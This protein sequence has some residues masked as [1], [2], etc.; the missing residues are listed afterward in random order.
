MAKGWALLGEF[1]DMDPA[2]V[3]GRYFGCMHHEESRIK[4]PATAH[5]FHEDSEKGT[6]T[7]AA[8]V[9]HED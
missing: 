3:L 8:S 2:E 6:K 7:A 9:R 1:I 4:L 5:P